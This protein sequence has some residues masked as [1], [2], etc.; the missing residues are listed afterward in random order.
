MA[1]N[2]IQHRFLALALPLL[3]ATAASSA[4]AEEGSWW[5]NLWLTADQQ[6]QRLVENGNFAEAAQRFT[7]PDATGAAF[8]EAGQFE[9]AAS[10]WGRSE[11]AAAAYNRGNALIF[12]GDY[13]TAISSYELALERRPDWAEAEENLSIA[14]ARKAALAPPDDDAGGTGGQLEADEY[15]FDD[16]GRVAGSD[17]EQVIEAVDQNLGDDAMRAMWLRRVETR[18]A[19]FLSAKF[20]YQLSRTSAEEPTND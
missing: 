3:L 8:F 9:E 11:S 20:N 17:Q 1:L 6:A 2:T 15:V 18:P 10:V 14:E 16:S 12:L 4:H 7:T 19:D 13:D 5:E